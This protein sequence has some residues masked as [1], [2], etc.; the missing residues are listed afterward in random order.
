MALDA[1]TQQ[2]IQQKA[3]AGIKLSDPN[4]EKAAYYAK[5]ANP[6]A[7]NPAEVDRTRSVINDRYMAGQDLTSQFAHYKNLTGKD[8]TQSDEYKGLA[9]NKSIN[10][11]FTKQKSMIDGMFNQQKES[12]LAAMRAQRDKAV[13]QINQQKSEVAPQYQGMRNQTDAVNQ[14]NVQKLRELMAANGL[15]ASGENVSANAAMNNER[16]NSLNSLNL[17][18]Q[19]T[20]NDYDRRISDL[21][22][23]ADEMALGASI[24][25]ERSRSM[26]DAFN[27]AQTMGYQRYRDT[28]GDQRYSQEW[29]AQEQQRR[30]DN[31]WR[32]H[33]FNNMSASEKTQFEWTKQQYGEEAAWRMFETQYNGEL[34]K[35]QSQ[36][37]LDYYKQGFLTP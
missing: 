10:D 8:Y 15:N 25:A 31:A 18:E 34:A 32:T 1:R 33:T 30:Q 14:Q 35:S 13:G 9:V 29:S 37:E 23:P 16:V 22:N 6:H 27:Q 2:L 36:A 4:P 5:L 11:M 21:D 17:Q 24:E 19:Q 12:Q 26:Y 28:V 20:M 3:E 7:T